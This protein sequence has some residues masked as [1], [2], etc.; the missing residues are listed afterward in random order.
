MKRR[1]LIIEDNLKNRKLEKD[2]LEVAG[3]EVLEAEGPKYGIII[4]NNEKPDLIIMD[5]RLP[6]MRGTEAARILREDK[7]LD[8]TP[9]IFVTASVLHEGADELKGIK[10]SGY[11]SKP[12]NT[13]TFAKEIEK[14]LNRR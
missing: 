10:N 13:R 1:I 14:Y 8:N 12:I 7:T 6:N 4:A 2:L 5:V 11:I 9:I 3:Y